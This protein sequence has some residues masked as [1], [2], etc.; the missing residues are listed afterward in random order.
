[1]KQLYQRI[2]VENESLKGLWVAKLNLSGKSGLATADDLAVYDAKLRE[3]EDE[4]ERRKDLGTQFE[5]VLQRTRGLMNADEMAREEHQVR[6]LWFR[7]CHLG[8]TFSG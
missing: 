6:V 8:F 4:L 2:S 7:C 5:V 1:M 3:L